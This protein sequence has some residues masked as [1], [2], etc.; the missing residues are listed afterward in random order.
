MQTHPSHFTSVDF[1]FRYC[2]SIYLYLYRYIDKVASGG[3]QPVVLLIICDLQ[4]VRGVAP[5]GGCLQF[6]LVMFY[7]LIR[8]LLI[9][10][11]RRSLPPPAGAF[12][13]SMKGLGFMT[14]L[15]SFSF[16]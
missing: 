8:P 9:L 7:F 5:S 15:F 11:P 14:S 1:A 6:L 16:P 2:I 3:L 12:T 10:P 4:V 13:D